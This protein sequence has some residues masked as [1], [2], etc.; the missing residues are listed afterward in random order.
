MFNDLIQNNP[1]FQKFVKDNEGKS[2]EQIAKEN[3][4]PMD[5]LNKYIR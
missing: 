2:I 3:N 1:E 5:V 4:I